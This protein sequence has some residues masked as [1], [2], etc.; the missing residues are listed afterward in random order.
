VVR[1]IYKKSDCG[2]GPPGEF[3]YATDDRSPQLE[4]YYLE[5][6][7]ILDEI[8][9]LYPNLEALDVS[10]EILFISRFGKEAVAGVGKAYRYKH[11]PE[12]R[13]LN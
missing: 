10:E 2:S 1:E 5:F 6:E 7:C 13:D 9:S 12:Y 3:W 4:T 8:E 11:N